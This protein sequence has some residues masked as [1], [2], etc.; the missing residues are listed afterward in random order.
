MAWLYLYI[1]GAIAFTLTALAFEEAPEGGE[2]LAF[3]G[4]ALVWPIIVLFAL[5]DREQHARRNR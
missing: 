3:F 2:W 4:G 5:V 1:G